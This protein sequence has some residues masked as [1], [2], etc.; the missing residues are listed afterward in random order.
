M[1]G[2]VEGASVWRANQGMSVCCVRDITDHSRRL[3]LEA[4]DGRTNE[5]VKAMKSRMLRE[6]STALRRGSP[7]ERS[8]LE[9]RSPRRL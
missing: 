5:L 8:Q 9:E 2:Q 4:A 1:G 3:T 6:Q 7:G